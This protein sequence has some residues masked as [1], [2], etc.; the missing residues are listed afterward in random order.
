M[1]TDYLEMSYPSNVFRQLAPYYSKRIEKSL[2]DVDLI[3]TPNSLRVCM[4]NN[5][6]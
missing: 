6:E 5:P 4:D 2:E 1:I 3:G